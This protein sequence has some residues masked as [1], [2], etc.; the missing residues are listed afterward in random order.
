AHRD[1]A[2]LDRALG[3]A[4]GARRRIIVT[5]SVFSMDGDR[6]PLDSMVALAR[7]HRAALVV[8][9]A[10]AIGVL[11]PR[12]R[13]LC[14]ELGVAEGADVI[15]GTFG[16]ALGSFGAFVAAKRPLVELLLNRARPF[17]FSTALPPVVCAA[18]LEAL[19]II[20]VEGELRRRLRGNVDRLRAGVHAPS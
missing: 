6:A 18:S 2:A 7:D 16:K 12:G 20:S 15:V 11:G 9:E 1:L 17:V 14:A 10:H 3:E 13:G 19:R 8:D 5:E 4:K